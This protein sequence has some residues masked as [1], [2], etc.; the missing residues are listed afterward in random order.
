MLKNKSGFVGIGAYAGNQLLPFYKD[1]YPCLFAN[2]ATTDLDSLTEVDE[3]YKYQIPGGEGC[4]RDRIKSRELFRKDIDNI[5]NE[6]KEKLPGIEYLFVVASL[7]GGTGA[8]SVM[9]MKRVAMNDL[10]IKACIVITVLPNTKTESIQALI[11]S[12]ET[13]A[14]LEALEEP[15]TMFI[16][17]NDKNNNK[18]K[19][20][21]I[22]FCH[23]DALLTLDCNS[24]LGNIDDA[25]V[26]QMLC[27]RGVSI[28][29]K[30]GKDKSDIQNLISTFHN[31]VYAPLEDDKVIKYIGLANSGTGHSIRMEDVYEEVGIPLDTYIQYEAKYK[32]CVLSGLSL[33][34]KKMA[35]IKEIIDSNKDT[36]KRNLTAQNTNRLSKSVGF[37]DDI[38]P[39]KK[40]TEKKKSDRD[41]LF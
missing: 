36:I 16:L 22:F 25:E 9:P 11:N 35:E 27:S 31:N 15:G 14:E 39:E 7:G 12:Y 28:I 13:L 38:V 24:A 21:E 33:P 26:E 17:D 30:L 3:Q 5:I 10:D 20:N 41:L 40:S 4:N 8:G 6:V 37:F 23:L 19:I 32:L 29:S 34:Y 2:T 1:G 18:M